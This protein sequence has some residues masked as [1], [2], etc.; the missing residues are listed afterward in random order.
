MKKGRTA[1]PG[2]A[3]ALIRR[4]GDRVTSARVQI[5]A[6][7]LNAGSALT[8][9]EV[10]ARL[11]KSLSVD[12]VTVYRVLEWLTEVGLA[13]RITESDRI[14]R[15]IALPEGRS[16][17]SAHFTCTCCSQT[18]FLPGRVSARTPRLPAGYR[19]QQR[20]LSIR[21]LCSECARPGH[22]RSTHS[23]RRAAAAR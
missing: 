21:G 10:E 4:T 9:G 11:G 6:V 20:E 15:F 3:E 1:S 2:V 7:L 16:S 13:H 8:H 5:L 14:W 22:N 17:G 18:I 19:V 12:R 23:R